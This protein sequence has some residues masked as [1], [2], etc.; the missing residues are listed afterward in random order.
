MRI[1]RYI[2]V[3]VVALAALPAAAVFA[4]YP[5]P[6]GA[7]TVVPNQPSVAPNSVATFTVTARTA[8]GAPAPGVSGTASTTTPGATVLT[9]TFTTNA[10]GTAQI[11]VQTGPNPG[12]L[13]VNV[14]CGALS[15]SGVVSVAT[16]AGP[17]PKPPD[18]GLGSEDSSSST[19]PMLWIVA[20]I[21]LLGA[22]GATGATVLVRRK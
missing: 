13:S 8:T 15:T 18:T 16:P 9:P 22:A 4:Q 19:L 6:I 1:A 3:A 7:C 12:N 14:T 20:G 21:A 17:Q 5:E 11:S 10:A 2:A